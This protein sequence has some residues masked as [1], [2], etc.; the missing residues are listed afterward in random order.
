[1][2]WAI[3]RPQFPDCGKSAY[4]TSVVPWVT[5]AALWCLLW[6]ALVYVHQRQFAS[7]TPV[8]RLN[9]LHALVTTGDLRI[10]AYEANTPD[11][12]EFFGHY[13]SDKAPGTAAL[14]LPAFAAAAVALDNTGVPLQSK[15]GWL[16]SSWVACAGSIGVVAATGGTALFAWLCHWVPPRAALLTVLGVFLG[17]APLP[18]STLM[19][20]H[21][22][23]VGFVSLALWAL[24]QGT[25]PSHGRSGEARCVLPKRSSGLIAWGRLYWAELLAGHACGWAIASEYTA[26]LVV[27]GLVVTA[28]LLT[29]RVDQEHSDQSRPNPETATTTTPVPSTGRGSLARIWANR[30]RVVAFGCAGLPP[31]LLIPA[32]S[33]ACFGDPF[34]LPYSLQASFPQMQEGL[35][36]IKWPDLHTAWRLL[37]DPAKG[38]LYWSPFLVLAVFGYRRLWQAAPAWFWLTYLVPVLQLIVI[39]GRVW[40][41]Q[42]GP[43]LGPRYLAPMLPLLALPC[44]LGLERLPRLGLALIVI[45]IGLTGIATLTDVCPGYEVKVPLTQ[46]HLPLLGSGELSPNLGLAAGL[47]PHVS[48]ALFFGWLIGGASWLWWRLAQPVA[49]DSAPCTST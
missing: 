11:K 15:Q 24:G 6:V 41:W 45:S 5:L 18:Y 30:Y 26:G 4:P 12:A 20:S 17:A 32:Y 47:T 8:S 25:Y 37:F 9:A 10:D 43:T 29:S 35:Y 2:T 19:F 46:L 38:L 36:A 14:A 34:L 42:A 7:P 49:N 23:V 39:S 44:A 13:Y 22:S 16:I 27:L 1:M 40:D 48:V 31:L 3:P 28:F 21:A 33:Y